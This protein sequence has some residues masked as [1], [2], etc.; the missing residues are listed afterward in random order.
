MEEKELE[1]V[2]SFSKTFKEMIAKNDNTTKYK[3]WIYIERSRPYTEQEIALTISG[4]SLESKQKLSRD[5]FNKDGFYKRLIIYYATLLK[6][7]GVLIPNP[8]F[9]QELSTSYIQKRYFN[10]MNFVDELKIPVVATNCAL[11]LGAS[12]GR[13]YR[14]LKTH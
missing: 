12:F 14:L 11:K 7:Q 10:A 5:Y 6:Y 1:R 3:N 4:N 9:G 2:S 8:S 13:R